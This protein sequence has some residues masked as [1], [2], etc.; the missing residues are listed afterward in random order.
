MKEILWLLSGFVFSV[1]FS[2]LI[3]ILVSGYEEYEI[4]PLGIVGVILGTLCGFI[5]VVVLIILSILMLGE[6]RRVKEWASTPI[7]TIKLKGDDK[8]EV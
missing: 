1:G 2:F 3:Q 8:D 5:T 7:K 4:T 6:D